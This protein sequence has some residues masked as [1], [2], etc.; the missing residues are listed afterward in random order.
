MPHRKNMNLDYTKKNDITIPR[1]PLEVQL[2]ITYRCNNQC[3]HCWISLPAGH[4]KKHEELSLEEIVRIVAEARSLGARS[5]AL[6]GGEPMVR[7]DF[8]EIF[9]IVTGKA[10][11]YS[12][13]TNGTL[14]TP[15]IAR[16]L[17]RK[18]YKMVALYGATAAVHDHITRNP[19]SF[20]AAIR[21]MRYLDEAGAGF[22]VQVVPLKDNFHQFQAMTELAESLSSRWRIGASW[23]YL[24]ADGDPARN[25]EIMRQRLDP[26]SVV[27]LDPIHPAV[28]AMSPCSRN[29]FEACIDRRRNIHID[30][31]GDASFCS[32][33]TDPALRYSLRSGTV[34]QAW[35]EFIPSLKQAVIGDEEFDNGCGACEVRN[36]C[37]WCPVYARLEHGR[38]TAKIDYLCRVAE[39]NAIY[40][41]YYAD[42]H[43]R[44]FQIAGITVKV[45]SE[46]PMGDETFSRALRPFMTK[47]PGDD[48]VHL[49]HHFQIPPF[50]PD[51]LGERVYRNIPWEIYESESFWHYLGLPPDGDNR[52]PYQMTVFDRHHSSA[53]IFNSN[54]AMFREGDL[55]SLAMFPSDQV[56][57]A[58]LLAH[59]DACYLHGSGI[60]LDDC[61]LLFLGH[62]GAGK[63]TITKMLMND[64]TVLCDDR[65]I[66]RRWPEG[67]KIHGTWSHGEIPL[68]SPLGAPLKGIFL[69]EQAKKN[70]LVPVT[71]PAEKMGILAAVVVRPLLT[72][73]WWESVLDLISRAVGETPLFRLRFDL[74]GGVKPLL[75][76]FLQEAAQ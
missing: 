57:L 25:L 45:E 9:D 53:D 69:L 74:S 17:K 8:E 20:E 11:S 37:R 3:R 68:V 58:R 73:Q 26:A 27:Q 55:H 38:H 56:W 6:S 2:D 24:G 52:N 13:N 4:E 14:V 36:N 67:F 10:I 41:N 51:S 49:R 16:L 50:D 76:T 22:T 47:E 35:E 63:S 54:R 71:K 72:R 62:S 5:W 29:L 66:M 61:G 65:V 30:P 1:L 48:I 33:A 40:G 18:G 28:E 15:A 59:R 42:N 12:L 34:R 60:V 32:F 64:G 75:E 23:L 31:Y 7:P 70:A 39:Q 46:E 44:H 19:G 21:G 43:I